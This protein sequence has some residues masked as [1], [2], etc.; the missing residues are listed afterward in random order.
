L[1]VFPRSQAPARRPAARLSSTSPTRLYWFSQTVGPGRGLES[2]IPV[3]AR[4]RRPVSL[5][6]RGI[7]A[8]GYADELRRLSGRS[9]FKG[10][11]EFLPFAAPSEMARL[12]S[13]YD[14]GLSLESSPPAN[15]DLCLTNKIFVYLLAGLPS[16][17]TPTTAQSQLAGELGEAAFLLD[18]EK[19]EAAATAL[20]FLLRDPVRLTAARQASWQLGQERFN[21][22]QEQGI[23]IA[24]IESALRP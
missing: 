21:W 5:H 1:N 8:S 23:F 11:I 14:L 19:P 13:E 15:R 20:D 4:L 17:L 16:I 10:D 22:D 9:G 24:A 3:L 6:L 18:L 12:A 7:V 2:L